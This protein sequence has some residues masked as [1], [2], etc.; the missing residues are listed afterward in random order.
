MYV[1]HCPI[2]IIPEHPVVTI[3]IVDPVANVIIMMWDH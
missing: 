2:P 1:G 3:I